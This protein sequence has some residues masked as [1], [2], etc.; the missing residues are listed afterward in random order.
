MTE[1]EIEGRCVY[2][3]VCALK[4]DSLLLASLV[5]L[6]SRV[7]N[8]L[9]T[10]PFPQLEM[11]VLL[12]FSHPAIPQMV[13]GMWDPQSRILRAAVESIRTRPG[14]QGGVHSHA[15]PGES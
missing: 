11:R 14:G 3:R 13:S 1:L 4:H 5:N 8:L 12:Q 6:P 10:R 7:S 15:E 9:V 2:A